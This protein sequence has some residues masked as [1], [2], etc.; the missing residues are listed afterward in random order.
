MGFSNTQSFF[1]RNEEILPIILLVNIFQRFVNFVLILSILT[2]L[3]RLLVL[4]RTHLLQKDQLVTTLIPFVELCH[5]NIV[6]FSLQQHWHTVPSFHFFPFSV[7]I[8]QGRSSTAST[9]TFTIA[10]GGTWKIKVSQIECSNLMRY[11]LHNF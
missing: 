6:G 5:L 7:Y 10:T 9:L 1:V 4:A 3:R 11:I 2:S 8:E